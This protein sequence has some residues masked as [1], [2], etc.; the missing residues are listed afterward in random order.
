MML[1]ILGSGTCVPSIER[2]APANYIRVGNKQILID[3]G[4]GTLLQ[5]A[6]NGL[7]YKEIDVVCISHFHS[8]HVSDLKSFIQALD[9]TP[10][11]DRKKDLVLIGPIG[12]KKF[13]RTH[14]NSKPRPNTYKIA[15]KEIRGTIRFQDFSVLAHKTK[16]FTESVA[17][18]FTAG[19]KSIAISGDTDFLSSFAK[20]F[21]QVDLLVLECSFTNKDKIRGHLVPKECGLIAQAAE[22][23]KLVLTHIYPLG[24]GEKRLRETKAVF[25][26]TVLAEDSMSFNI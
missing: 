7:S 14:I 21:K 8:D 10:K 3:C 1:K 25:K 18:R 16:H 9:W 24:S 22:A 15:I 23:K 4:P 12:F 5:L 20:F 17:Y 6:K 11:F 13:Y 2:G 26:N 19:N